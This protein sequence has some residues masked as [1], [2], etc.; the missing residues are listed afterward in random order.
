M[1][2]DI[3]KGGDIERCR[4]T[5]NR[6]SRRRE[7]EMKNWTHEVWTIF[8]FQDVLLQSQQRVPQRWNL[9]RTPW[10]HCLL[11]SDWLPASPCSV[12]MVAQNKASETLFFVIRSF[13]VVSQLSNQAFPDRN[14]NAVALSGSSCLSIT[15]PGCK[16]WSDPLHTDC[17]RAEGEI[18][19]NYFTLL[20]LSTNQMF[21]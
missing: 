2:Q 19:L 21:L 17:H 20:M 9:T 18:G 11:W 5:P 3:I 13:P 1:A 15:P 8:F 12:W 4:C 14:L 7:W 10:F 16:A 6:S